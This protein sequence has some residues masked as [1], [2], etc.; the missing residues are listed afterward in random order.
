MFLFYTPWKDQ[1]TFSF[2]IFS[3][4]IEREHCHEMGE[5]HDLQ[6]CAKII[7]GQNCVRLSDAALDYFFFSKIYF[8]PKQ[9]KY[10]MK[11]EVA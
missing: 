1:K 4:G 10:V 2:L 6:H 3:E 5:G 8:Y 7:L 9:F 11:I